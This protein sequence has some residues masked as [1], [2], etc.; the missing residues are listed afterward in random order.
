MGARYTRPMTDE[1]A[2]RQLIGAE[3]WERV[4]PGP[5]QFVVGWEDADQFCAVV[6]TTDVG[7]QLCRACP[8]EASTRARERGHAASATCPAGVRLLAFPA[9]S[10][11][12][13]QAALLRVAPPA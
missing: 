5:A 3:L 12:R 1:A 13:T 9:P 11:S 4:A 7:L 6:C 2:E 10:G 8:T